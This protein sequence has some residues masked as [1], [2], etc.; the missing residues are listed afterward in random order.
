MEARQQVSEL[1]RVTEVVQ[2]S[3]QP[4]SQTGRKRLRR[5]TTVGY[6]MVAAPLT[7]NGLAHLAAHAASVGGPMFAWNGHLQQSTQLFILR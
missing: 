1:P 5:K 4:S 6:T 2:T 7:E 3:V